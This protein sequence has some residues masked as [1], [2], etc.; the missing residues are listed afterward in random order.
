MTHDLEQIYTEIAKIQRL[1]RTMGSKS[2]INTDKEVQLVRRRRKVPRY[3]WD[4]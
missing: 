2:S 1:M 4:M 3:S